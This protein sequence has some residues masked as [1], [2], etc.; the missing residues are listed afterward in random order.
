M[1]IG[2]KPYLQ[3][4]SSDTK[5]LTELASHLS[6]RI[7]ARGMENDNVKVFWQERKLDIYLACVA[8]E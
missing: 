3:Y 1:V 8:K 6:R 2:K 5:P 4:P 7:R